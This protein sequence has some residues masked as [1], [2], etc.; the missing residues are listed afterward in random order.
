MTNSQIKYIA[1][2]YTIFNINKFST[3]IAP[4]TSSGISQETSNQSVGSSRANSL[5]QPI[6]PSPSVVSDKNNEDVHVS[7]NKLLYPILPTLYKY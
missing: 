7:L 1:F 2:K 6:S 5:P 4:R 3:P